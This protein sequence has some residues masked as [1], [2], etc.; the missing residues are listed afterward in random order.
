MQCDDEVEENRA[1]R[2][3]ARIVEVATPEQWQTYHD[4]RRT[5]L[6]EAR[7]LTGYDENHP[8]DRMPGHLPVLL[9]FGTTPV[10]AA[11]LDLVGDRE[12]CVRT[13][14]IRQ[15]SQRRGFGRA[16]MAG[17]DD[18]AARHG[19]RKLNVH[20]APE[21]VGFYEALGWAVVDAARDNPMLMKELVTDV[22]PAEARLQAESSER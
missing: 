13:V 22:G 8:D 10:G 16:L 15:D 1:W 4:I 2:D 20:A 6:F 5:V 3:G 7:G 18:I 21:A 14:A 12:A 17:L 9:M 11:R 19:V